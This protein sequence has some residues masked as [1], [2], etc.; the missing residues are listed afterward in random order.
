[1][2]SASVSV[3]LARKDEGFVEKPQPA[4]AL[5]HVPRG[6]EIAPIPHDL[7]EPLVFDLRY[8]YRGVPGRKQGRGADRLA[9]LL[10]QGVHFVAK[11][12]TV[13]RVGVEIEIPPVG[14]EL[15]SGRLQQLMA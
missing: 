7:G 12:G 8:V 1:M 2:A 14:A 13:V 11:D 15:G 9:D 10:G 3:T 4:V 5:Q 6:L